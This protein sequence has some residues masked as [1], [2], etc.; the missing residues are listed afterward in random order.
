VRHSCRELRLP[1]LHSYE[2]LS[3]PTAYTRHHD[4]VS[5]VAYRAYS[6]TL[7][8]AQTDVDTDKRIVVLHVLVF[9]V[10]CFK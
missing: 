10:I 4:E 6:I 5:D 1:V 7:C 2:H 9:G 3:T 8:V